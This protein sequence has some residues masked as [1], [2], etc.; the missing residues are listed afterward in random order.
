[1]KKEILTNLDLIQKG[2][3]VLL[4]G[5]A[6]FFNVS[7][8]EKLR[9]SEAKIVYLHPIDYKSNKLHFSQYIK[10]EVGSE[11]GICALLLSYFVDESTP[12]IKAFI[13]DLDIGY[14]SA[15]TS[16]GEE[17]LEEV[18]EQTKEANNIFLF[19]SE[20][21]LGHKKAKN[22]I[23]L[24]GILNKYSSLNL[25]IENGSSKSI[26]AINEYNNEMLE[27]VE[28]LD[29]YDGLIICKNNNIE[30]NQLLGGVSFSKMAKI[31]D[32]DEVLITFE[33]Q[34]IQRKFKID[35]NLQGT[36]ALCS[37]EEIQ[38]LTYSYKIVKIEKVD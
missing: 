2:D 4:L 7:L 15:E 29:S 13:D 32:G 21:F 25:I 27:D 26:Q 9:Q 1:M 12:T 10:Y 22:I 19:L 3:I 24:L 35:T 23:K 28:E 17:E 16:L 34:T 36:V 30:Q 11:E 37:N 38:L 8:Q 18:V 33:N 5:T 14:L 20:N 6:L 31:N